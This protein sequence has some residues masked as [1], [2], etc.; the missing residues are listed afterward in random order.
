M[1][2]S[3]NKKATIWVAGFIGPRLGQ[4][5]IDWSGNEKTRRSGFLKILAETVSVEPSYEKSV[6]SIPTPLST[7]SGGLVQD[8]C[9]H[10]QNITFGLRLCR[11]LFSL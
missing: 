3:I 6:I 7:P 9:R 2:H 5:A 8:R 1:V 4:L 10:Y 11:P